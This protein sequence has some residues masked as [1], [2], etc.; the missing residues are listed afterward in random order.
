MCSNLYLFAETIATHKSLSRFYQKKSAADKPRNYS[1]PSDIDALRK[2]VCSKDIPT[3]AVNFRYEK[4]T[5]EAEEEYHIC[6]QYSKIELYLHWIVCY[7]MKNSLN[8]IVHCGSKGKNS[9][10]NPSYAPPNESIIRI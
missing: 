6:S 7:S 1:F 8:I 4:F 3:T 2:V 10:C 5:V 9:N